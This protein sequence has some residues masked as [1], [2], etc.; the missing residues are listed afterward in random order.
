M[1]RASQPLIMLLDGDYDHTLRIADELRKCLDIRLIGIG[2][3]PSSCLLRSNYPSVKDV[4]SEVDIGDYARELLSLIDKHCPDFVLPVG[5]RSVIALDLIRSEIPETMFLLPASD[6]LHTCLDKA[7]VLRVAKQIG[8]GTPVDYTDY[9]DS[10]NR[11]GRT[12]EAL[13]DLKFP[14]FL[15]ASQEGGP[16]I[17]EKVDCY[18]EFWPTYDRLKQ[19]LADGTLLVQEH[20]GGDPATYG[21]GFLFL[22][23]ESVLAFGQEELRSIPRSGGSGTRV[24]VLQNHELKIA[25]E[26]LLNEVGYEGVALVE[27]K[28]RS[29]GSFA[30][31]EVN[32]KFWA[33]YSL[34]SKCNYH[35]AAKLVGGHLGIPVKT[36]ERKDR[37][38]MVF[39]LRE[40]AY[41]AKHWGRD[42]ESFVKS[43]MA[44]LLPPAQWDMNFKELWW[45][46]PSP[47]DVIT[48]ATSSASRTTV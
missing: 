38:E 10:V 36:Y 15:K 8:I 26:R 31:M 22:E 43:A 24:R 19:K 41:C 29:D 9:I 23:G 39:P 4:A 20:V 32:P 48:K 47:S 16:K 30:L 37:G 44:M 35:F 3:K 5:A 7:S 14:V 17:R 33:S 42:G 6:T 21:Y 40:A 12:E 11:R 25:S 45:S 27:Y 28:K 18:D 13:R 34:A 46:M 1:V 2:S